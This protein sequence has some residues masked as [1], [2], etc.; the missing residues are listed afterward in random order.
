MIAFFFIIALLRTLGFRDVL[1]R[2]DCTHRHTVFIKNGRERKAQPKAV[3]AR[4][5]VFYF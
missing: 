3:S 4:G 1:K 5:S 2:T